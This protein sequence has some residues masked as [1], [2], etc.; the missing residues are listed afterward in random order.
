MC[1]C[2]SEIKTLQ[3]SLIE[4]NNKAMD[5]WQSMDP[6]DARQKDEGTYPT[7]ISQALLYIA[8]QLKAMKKVKLL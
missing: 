4:L 5:C 2:C 1:F 7:N 6:T 3:E 8:H